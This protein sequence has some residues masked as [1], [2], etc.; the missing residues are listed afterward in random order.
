MNLAN[1]TCKF[2]DQITLLD[3]FDVVV[4]PAFLTK[5]VRKYDDVTYQLLGVA[6]YK[7][8]EEAVIAGRLVKDMTLSRKQVLLKGE[9]VE[10]PQIMNS[11]PTSFFVLT[12]SNHKLIYVREEAFAPPL[13]AFKSTISH[14]LK[15]RYSEWS[16]EVYEYL[17][18]TDE[19]LTWAQLRERWPAPTLDVTPISNDQSVNAYLKTFKSINSVQLKI[20]NTN[21]EIDN[22][23]L[24]EGLR[25]VKGDIGA[26]DLVLRTSKKGDVGLNKA[27]VA[28]LVREQANQGNTQI[29][30]SGKNIVG[31]KQVANNEELKLSV[32]IKALGR[33]VKEAASYL[34]DKLADQV[35]QG[36]VKL[37]AP[38][39][40]ALEQVAEIIEERKL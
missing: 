18:D 21:H 37:N 14:F 33:R 7:I 32:P 31:D 17:K 28:G 12:L 3:M 26:E 1:F 29:V 4:L 16:K 2:G 25:G 11:A 13:S 39:V 23:G 5:A 6:L 38:P 40:R 19:R 36:I 27:A 15:H 24:F 22:S 34:L 10:S 35:A 20:L 9:I 30:V 8:G